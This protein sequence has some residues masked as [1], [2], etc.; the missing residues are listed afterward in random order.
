MNELLRSGFVKREELVV[1]AYVT[2]QNRNQLLAPLYKPE[3]MSGLSCYTHA[4][5]SAFTPEVLSQKVSVIEDAV[6]PVDMVMVEVPD[7]LKSDYTWAG[8]DETVKRLSGPLAEVIAWFE[9]QAALN[10]AT[11]WYSFAAGTP[12]SFVLPP[13]S[14]PSPLPAIGAV[15]ETTESLLKSMGATPA[16]SPLRMAA[17]QYPVGLGYVPH[18]SDPLDA[19][20]WTDDE[21]RLVA[22]QRAVFGMTDAGFDGEEVAAAGV[23]VVR[24]RG[25]ADEMGLLRLAAEPLVAKGHRGKLFMYTGAH[26][27]TGEAMQGAGGAEQRDHTNMHRVVKELNHC[28]K[29]CIHLEMKFG[30]VVELLTEEEKAEG[31]LPDEIAVSWAQVLNVSMRTPD[32]LAGLHDFMWILEQ[33]IK[34]SLH[35]GL[36]VMRAH[37]R[38]EIKQWASLYK[39]GCQMLFRCVTRMLEI[40]AAERSADMSVHLDRAAPALSTSPSLEHRALRVLLSSGLHGAVMS[41]PLFGRGFEVDDATADDVEE[42]GK[43]RASGANFLAEAKARLSSFVPPML[44]FKGQPGEAT[45]HAVALEAEQVATEEEPPVKPIASPYAGWLTR[46]RDELSRAEAR[47]VVHS[48]RVVPVCALWGPDSE[49]KA[50]HSN[51]SVG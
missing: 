8:Y 16:S 25:M 6:G 40:D 22:A 17:L 12:P 7:I 13:K 39:F 23:D 34:P 49:I 30:A 3:D 41:E 15:L 38:I 21:E 31:M 45:Q 4:G 44:G 19:A 37:P 5:L 2:P 28:F 10:P 18:S 26:S 29:S 51:I 24:L 9:E 43:R 20:P 46:S 1:V 27:D 35:N 32:G 36:A 14:L 11:P 33:R 48:V 50:D 47:Q 42:A